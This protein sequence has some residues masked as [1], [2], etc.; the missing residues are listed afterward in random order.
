MPLVIVSYILAN[1]AYFLVLPLDTIGLTAEGRPQVMAIITSPANRP[2]VERYRQ[3]AERLARAE[4]V[5]SAEARR[6]AQ[7]GKGIVWFDGGLH[8]TEVLGAQQLGRPGHVRRE[9][10]ARKLTVADIEAALRRSNVE[11]PAGIEILN[12]GIP[13][14][15]S[16]VFDIVED[17]ITRYDVDA[18]PANYDCHANISFA[19]I[20]PVAPHYSTLLKFDAANYPNEL[21]R[22][23]AQARPSRLAKPASFRRLLTGSVPERQ[24][25][26]TSGSHCR[27]PSRS[28]WRRCTST[29]GSTRRGGMVRP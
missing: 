3:I 15:R 6:L 10:A 14:V 23:T 7:E 13:D 26:R 9:L 4:G 11:L 12:P 28:P 8:A 1:V 2:N 18:E 17:I 19:F 29:A 20:H 24:M 22:Q 25:T 21:T 27:E 5:D 16:Y